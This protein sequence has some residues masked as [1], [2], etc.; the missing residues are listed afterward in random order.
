MMR[1]LRLRLPLRLR[2][3]AWCAASILAI[4]T[5]V[6]IGLLVVQWQAMREALDHHLEEDLEVA[7]EMLVVSGGGVTWRTDS[8]RDLGYD[9]APQRWVEVYGADGRPL[10]FRGLAARAP[11]RDSLPDAASDHEGVSTRQTPAGAF[12][13]LRV[14]DRRIGDL[15]VRIRVA[16]SE[17]SLR[18]DLLWL[19]VLFSVAAPL[20]VV[21]SAAVGYGI[22]GR[23]LAPLAAMA[24]RAQSISADHLSERLPVD[25]D[26]ELGQLAR[27]FNETF[28]R[29]EAS[30]A[31]LR[32]FAADASHELRTPLT[33]IRSVG[34]VGLREA[35]DPAQYQE[36]VGSMLEEADR[37]TRM[38]DTLLTLA[39]WESGRVRPV[40]HMVDLRGLADEVCAQLSVLAEEAGVH[41]AVEA[42]PPA[43]ALSDP[44]MVRQALNNLIDNAIKFTGPGTEVKVSLRAEPHRV[45]LVVDDQGPGIPEAERDRVIER[46]Y[47]VHHG[48]G[49]SSRPGTG[50][51]LAIAH[52]AVTANGGTLAVEASPA[53]GARLILWLPALPAQT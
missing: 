46:F 26:D 9:A 6:L 22:A 13:R 31:R 12:V 43:S 7:A 20:S 15:P 38:V 34:E 42:G 36:V 48:D 3:A 5:P 2:L 11:I 23:A 19:F 8:E 4:L 27:I 16:R 18:A 1:R 32:Q 30:F 17:D 40:R 51:G 28:A 49:R 53:G 29:L 10:Y 52:W 44:V 25:S 24:E 33:A 14:A 21:V 50:L 39:G 41:L 35:R 45:G 47:R 37:L